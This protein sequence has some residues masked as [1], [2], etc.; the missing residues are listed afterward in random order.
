V[1]ALSKTFV[2]L[3]TAGAVVLVVAGLR[4]WWARRRDDQRRAASRTHRD[5][6]QRATIIELQERFD[7]FRRTA[8]ALHD[9]LERA[10]QARPAPVET[11]G[12]AD[13]SNSLSE[14]RDHLYV[15]RARL[16]DDELRALS[17]NALHASVRL[18]VANSRADAAKAWAE[19]VDGVT[20][21]LERTAALLQP[22]P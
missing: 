19:L 7:E 15:L 4:A 12:A 17:H 3:V 9:A 10:W 6:F 13:L 16:L 5:A 1:G 11:N 21:A 22:T 20:H 8:G 14:Q 2:G 18:Q